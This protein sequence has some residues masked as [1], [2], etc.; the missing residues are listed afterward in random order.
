ML[1]ALLTNLHDQSVHVTGP[2]YKQ[3]SDTQCIHV[4]L[5]TDIAVCMYQLCV[6]P[7]QVR[8]R[9]ELHFVGGSLKRI[10]YFEWSRVG[11]QNQVFCRSRLWESGLGSGTD[12]CGYPIRVEPRFHFSIWNRVEPGNRPS[13]VPCNGKS[14]MCTLQNMVGKR[15]CATH[16]RCFHLCMQSRRGNRVP[17]SLPIDIETTVELSYFTRTTWPNTVRSASMPV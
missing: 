13:L 2:I 17:A 5:C 1:S 10:G 4:L 6:V 11:P 9:L 8:C 7:S 15:P 3:F 16:K 12:A 14:R